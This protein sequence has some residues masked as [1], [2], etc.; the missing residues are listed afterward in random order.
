MPS[1][2][3]EWTCFLS[4]DQKN[5]QTLEQNPANHVAAHVSKTLEEM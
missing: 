1:K 4:T 5:M 3:Q 2:R